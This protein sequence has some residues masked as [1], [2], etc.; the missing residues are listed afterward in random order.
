MTTISEQQHMDSL[1][2][3][4]SWQWLCQ[5]RK[6]APA[7]A[8]IWD[9]RYRWPAYRESF[10]AQLQSGEYR[11]SPMRVVGR[12]RQVMWS[13]EDALA[14][15]WVALQLVGE[16]PLHEKCEH[17]KGHGG[18]QA[19]VQRVQAAINTKAYRW[20]CR[21]DIK[22]YYGVINTDT[23]LLQLTAYITRPALL[24]LLRQFLHYSVEEGG[25][26]HTPSQGIA[27]SCALSPLMGALHLWL[28]DNYFATQ[29][30]IYYARYMDDFLILTPTRWSLRRQVKQLNRYLNQFGFEK[31]PE[32]TFIGR[33]AK[34]FDWM[35]AWLTDAGVTDIAPRAKANHQEKL[36]R[37]YE[38]T[39]HWPKARQEKRVSEYKKRW[40]RWIRKDDNRTLRDRINLSFNG[41]KKRSHSHEPSTSSIA[42]GCVERVNGNIITD[43]FLRFCVLF[44]SLGLS[45]PSFSVNQFTGSYWPGHGIVGDVSP[46]HIAD[47]RPNNLCHQA[48]RAGVGTLYDTYVPYSWGT[49]SDGLYQGPQ[50]WGSSSDIF[51]VYTGTVRSTNPALLSALAHQ[52]TSADEYIVTFSESGAWSANTSS[53]VVPGSSGSIFAPDSINDFLTND[54]V[55]SSGVADMSV[56]LYIGPNARSGT[57]IIPG[58][59][60]QIHCGVSTPSI[61]SLMSTVTVLETSCSISI[62]PDNINVAGGRSQ[63]GNGELIDNGIIQVRGSCLT[64]ELNTNGNMQFSIVANNRT[65]SPSGQVD[66]A[67]TLTND[68]SD[69]V[70]SVTFHL[71]DVVDPLLLTGTKYDVPVT[72]E[73]F[74]FDVSYNI[75]DLK[76]GDAP[77]YGIGRGTA[78]FLVEWP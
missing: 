67:M 62:T 37:L 57:Y 27:R 46:I 16:I 25:N 43:F 34:G 66:R 21:T 53:Y 76:A 42:I 44:C 78:K 38:Q 50:L 73:N 20:V 47:Q 48:L 22:G 15:K 63:S 54:A 55:L 45:S 72:W 6:S 32:K 11:L 7:N 2:L 36:R 18:G 39:Q 60:P 51:L 19:S 1:H 17:L 5:A 59:S 40:E 52:N 33:I 41:R 3:D 77:A 28:V 31:H 49:S 58:I 26:F 9:L 29:E 14:L 74:N 8:D 71:P 68:S 23:L 64:G 35:G 13:A 65:M 70:G 61:L 10:L 12:E 24:S 75:Y 56:R 4:T 69:S 30:K